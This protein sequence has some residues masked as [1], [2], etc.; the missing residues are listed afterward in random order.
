MSPRFVWLF[1]LATACATSNPD[2]Q[3]G[4]IK[5]KS[6]ARVDTRGSTDDDTSTDEDTSTTDDDTGTMPTVDSSVTDT[7]TST[8]DTGSPPT[9]TGTTMDTGP[10][11][12]SGEEPEPNDTPSTAR[13]LG[14]IDDCDG[15][16][17]T[18]VGVLSSSSDVDVVTFDGSDSFGCSVNPYVKTTGP[19]KICLKPTCKSGTT[20]LKSCP[21]GTLTGGECCGTTEVELEINCT[22]TTSDDA[23]ITM[24]VRSNGSS[25]ACAGY[26]L[27]YHY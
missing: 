27:A 4:V 12:C 2:E 24:T 26:S 9:D 19:V 21:K 11:A 3:D 25:S 15:S 22:G 13:A 6:D 16:G 23:K 18:I 17:A 5:S 14:G 7:G 10:T 8:T 1:V 20:E